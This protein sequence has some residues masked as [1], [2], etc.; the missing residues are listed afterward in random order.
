MA[1]VPTL[2]L[3]AWGTLP[4]VTRLQLTGAACDPLDLTGYSR[5]RLS[6]A[7]DG[8]AVPVISLD[9]VDSPAQGLWPDAGAPGVVRLGVDQPT[10]ATVPDTTGA[11]LLRG[12]LVATD[13]AGVPEVMAIVEIAV[14]KGVTPP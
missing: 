6:L 12:E 7:L 13:P 3:R 4:L 11:F 2:R 5:W 14:E 8:Q 9:Q 10:W 1:N